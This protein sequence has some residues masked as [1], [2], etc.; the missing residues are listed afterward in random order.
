MSGKGMIINPVVGPEPITGVCV[1]LFV[2]NTLKV[3]LLSHLF[4]FFSNSGSSRMKGGSMTAIIL[5]TVFLLAFSRACDV[6]LATLLG[7][8][9][10]STPSPPPPPPP[11]SSPPS[12]A[13]CVATSSTATMCN[14]GSGQ[15][16][17]T[18]MLDQRQS[19]AAAILDVFH[20]CFISAYRSAQA[21]AAVQLKDVGGLEVEGLGSRML[22]VVNYIR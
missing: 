5:N 15:D 9:L 17:S 12:V 7:R 6:S 1:C 3:Y 18:H 22:W 16:T 21:G 2:C 14:G 11:S 4:R 20:S 13:S 8:S 19:S 10:S